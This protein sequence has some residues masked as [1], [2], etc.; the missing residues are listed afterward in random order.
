M[1]ITGI[2][3]SITPESFRNF[4]E[5]IEQINGGCFPYNGYKYIPLL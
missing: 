3:L 2:S 5:L 1:K 4:H